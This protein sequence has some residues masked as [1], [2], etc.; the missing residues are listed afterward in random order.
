MY[1][2]AE[3]WMSRS[4]NSM[5]QRLRI[6]FRFA[7]WFLQ[8]W[9]DI[10][11][12]QTNKSKKESI[13]IIIIIVTRHCH[14][15]FTFHS[16]CDKK[17]RMI[18]T[19]HFSSQIKKTSSVLPC[20][21][22]YFRLKSSIDKKSFLFLSTLSAISR[23]VQ[24][25]VNETEILY[26][27]I[28]A[29]TNTHIDADTIQLLLFACVCVC[30]WWHVCQMGYVNWFELGEWVSSQKRKR[31]LWWN[32]SEWN[33]TEQIRSWNCVFT[34]ISSSEYHFNGGTQCIRTHARNASMYWIQIMLI[35]WIDFFLN[36]D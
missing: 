12:A 4:F 1:R 3:T 33:G 27:Y 34:V 28:D 6:L 15:D 20:S 11:T 22:V 31:M 29:L 14:Y 35:F 23:I 9:Q 18:S 2:A 7:Q 26:K 17:N 19:C 36:H 32:T 13:I 16:T 24:T 8:V 10:D 5:E 30:S 21:L 25:Y